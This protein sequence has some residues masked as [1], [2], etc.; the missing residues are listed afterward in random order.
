MS[1][2]TKQSKE[3]LRAKLR[4]K[5]QQKKT[6]RMCRDVQKKQLNNYCEQVGI[7]PDELEVLQKTIQQTLGKK[8]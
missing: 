1:K 4:A 2:S 5:I 7:K 6:G 8:K 3:D